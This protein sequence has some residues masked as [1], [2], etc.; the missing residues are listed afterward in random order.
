MQE[1][2]FNLKIKQKPNSFLQEQAG[3][4]IKDK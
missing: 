3:F 2:F 4:G 1:D